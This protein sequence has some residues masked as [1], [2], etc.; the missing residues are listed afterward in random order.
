[1][2]SFLEFVSRLW[3]TL[4]TRRTDREMEEE[5]RHHLELTA[6]EAH[7][8]GDSPEGAVRAARLRAGSI[9][10]AMEHLRDQRGLP[11]LEDARRDLRHALRMLARTPGFT[12]VAVLTLA[13]GIGASTAIFS[14][15]NVIVLQ[16]LPYQDPDR[17]VVLWTDD[18]KRQLHE[19][20]VSYSS[21]A[22]WKERSQRFAELGFTTWTPL[23][24]TGNIEA[25]RMDAARA[26]ASTFTVLGASPLHGRAFSAEEERRGDR[27]A[28]VSQGFAERRFGSVSAALGQVLLL[29]GEPTA[30][31]GVMP[32]WFQWPRRDVQ[33]W[34][35][36]GDTRGRGFVI[37]RLRG[38]SSLEQARQEMIA[39]GN[40]LAEQYPSLAS[41]PD[42]PGFATALVPLDY[43]ITGNST[44][45]A[46]WVI[47]GAVL[48]MLLI[49]CANVATLVL[50]RASG[51]RRELAVRAALGA[52]RGRLVRQSL[53]ESLALALMGAMLGVALAVWLLRLLIVVAPP[54]LP[55][56]DAVSIDTAVL[57]FAMAVAM[58]CGASLGV[59]A[60]RHAGAMQLE[61]A[62]REG[63]RNQGTGAHGRRTRRRLVAVELAVTLTLVCGAGLLLRSLTQ[64]AHVPLGFE[65]RN[66]LAF[67]VVVPDAFSTAQRRVFYEDALQRLRALPGVRHVGVV[68]RLFLMSSPDATI[69]VEGRPESSQVP[70]MDDAA[71]PDLFTALR[72]PLRRGR[73]FTERDRNGSAH[74]AVVTERFAREFWRDED[75]VG[76]RFQ[77][78]D[79]RF[80]DRWITVVGVI[81]DMRR[82]GLEEEPYPQVFMPFAQ[83]PSRGADFVISTET[84]PQTLAATVIRTVG[85]ID[86]NVPVYQI[87][88][89]EQR[90]DALL[91]TRRFQAFLLALFAAGGLLLAAIGVYGLLRYVVMQRRQEI[92][93]RMAMG[94]SRRDVMAL[95][96]QEGLS[97][98]GVG[99]IVG[100]LAAFALSSWMGTLV[101]GISTKDPLTFAVA[102]LLLVFVAALACLEP[103]WRA[104]RVDPVHVLRATE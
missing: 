78:L 89:V 85:A 100:L 45:V 24:L 69:R 19:T 101:Y 83:S 7:R 21:Y 75:P 31:V 12:A 98:T 70:V 28:V 93:I 84:T 102:P 72:A 56:L 66:L 3:G 60:A 43:H 92:G 22:A 55:R 65:P 14:M 68:S 37:G 42:F 51:R 38:E 71:S 34:M 73:Y 20:L 50:A 58:L 36:L 81:A 32:A 40:Q 39:I 29:D 62:L 41:N 9:P 18:V 49:T 13:L 63:G 57:A 30:V 76:K 52:T 80:D 16:P 97:L 27:V 33:L 44:R 87:S 99:L 74:V 88:T 104:M 5:L 2:S 103:A 64:V 59:L 54:D 26:S 61:E 82:N 4:R 95:V 53:I 77:F 48:L 11:W 47:L 96:I 25:E 1:M 6:E 79:K 86:P 15:L 67:R 17:L 10:Q 90:L 46:L 91:T 23:T 8:R 94:A 35:P